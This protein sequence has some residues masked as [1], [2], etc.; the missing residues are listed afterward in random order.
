MVTWSKIKYAITV[1][2][3][4]ILGLCSRKFSDQLPFFVADNSGDMLWAAMVYF[5]FRCIFTTKSLPWAF[6][7]SLLF[8][9]VIE[10][11]QLYQVDWI[12]EIRHTT[13]GALVLGKGF[14]WVDLL[15]YLLGITI[16]YLADL[17][18]W[19][20]RETTIL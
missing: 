11:S 9:Y 13:L 16:A 20:N 4:I 7:A 6:G 19:K 18:L 17:F 1:V 14:L 2:V 12:N 3:I 5:G 15:R 10:F 8:S